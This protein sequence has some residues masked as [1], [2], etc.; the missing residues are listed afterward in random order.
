MCL[1]A[2]TMTTFEWTCSLL[3]MAHTSSYFYWDVARRAVGCKQSGNPLLGMSNRA[4]S[5]FLAAKTLWMWV[6][7]RSPDGKLVSSLWERLTCCNLRIHGRKLWVKFSRRD[8]HMKIQF[9]T[10]ALPFCILLVCIYWC[11]GLWRRN[12]NGGIFKHVYHQN[13]FYRLIDW[14]GNLLCKEIILLSYA[15][16]LMTWPDNIS[17]FH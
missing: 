6:R 10:E 1:E 11:K 8:F 3:F 14:K 16:D 2:V 5:L 7:W 15:Y 12:T 4:V 17:L 13:P 9:K